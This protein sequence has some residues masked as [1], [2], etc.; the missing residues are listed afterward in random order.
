MNAFAY[1]ARVRTDWNPALT[2]EMCERIGNCETFAQAGLAMGF[3]R[4]ALIGRFNRL[5]TESAGKL[6]HD[7]F[8]Q[9]L[10]DGW[11][12]AAIADEA[13]VSIG[14]VEARLADLR[15]RLGPQAR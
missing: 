11:S 14:A 7:S 6:I 12:I 4:S 8:T 9:M 2:T 1:E 15:R 10:A 3:S 5:M 13:G